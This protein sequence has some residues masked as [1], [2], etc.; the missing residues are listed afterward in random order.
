MYQV[1]MILLVMGLLGA[2]GLPLYV[3]QGELSACQG[4]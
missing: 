2:Q 4:K 3:G 1:S